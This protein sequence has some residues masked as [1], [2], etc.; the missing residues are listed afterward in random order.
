MIDNGDGSIYVC[1]VA[2]GL[3][4]SVP[5]NEGESLDDYLLRVAEADHPSKSSYTV[6]ESG[7]LPDRRWRNAWCKSGSSV[8]ID[9]NVARTIRMSELKVLRDIKL[10]E[11]NVEYDEA[12]DDDQDTTQIKADRKELRDMETTEQANLDAQATLT[13]I[14]N[15]LPSYLA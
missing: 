6:V 14:G 9:I 13:D 15:F 5:M 12:I 3:P 11:K 1:S 4:G 2:Y 8:A 10:K 7:D